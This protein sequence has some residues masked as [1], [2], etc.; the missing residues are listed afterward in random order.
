[1]LE[2]CLLHRATLADRCTPLIRGNSEPELEAEPAA[3]LEPEAEADADAAAEP[4]DETEV[5][6]EAGETAWKTY[7][8]RSHR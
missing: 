2:R 6:P 3:G 8:G 1:M 5:E 4:G 7:T